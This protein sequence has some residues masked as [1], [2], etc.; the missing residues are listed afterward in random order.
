MNYSFKMTS[1]NKKLII[2]SNKPLLNN[3]KVNK[4]ID[5]RLD[6]SDSDNADDNDN[7]PPKQNKNTNKY[8]CCTVS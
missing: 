4:Y 6:D 2:D 3:K 5:I 8:E 1:K 7:Y